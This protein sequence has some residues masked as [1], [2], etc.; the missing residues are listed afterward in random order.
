[1]VVKMAF[2]RLENRFVVK[3]PLFFS[4]LLKIKIF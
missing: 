4:I 2:F 1:M 3:C